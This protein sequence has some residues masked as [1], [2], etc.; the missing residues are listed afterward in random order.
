ML[1]AAS[2][3]PAAPR[4]VRF[5]SVES[6]DLG[7][8]GSV[9]SPATGVAQTLAHARTRV[10]LQAIDMLRG[11]VI[12]LMALD[13]VRDYFTDARFDPLDLT[14]THPAL[15]LT[16]W[17]TH[18]CAPTFIFLAGVS[19][20]LVSRRCTPAELSGFLFTRGLW[21]VILELTVVNYAWT[22]SV[23]YEIGVFLQVIWAIG[24]SMMLLSLLVRLP[25][26]WVGLF[27]VITIAGHNLLD[28]ISPASFGS[29][30]VLWKL[31]HVRAQTSFGLI[32]YPVG[33]WVGVMALGYALGGIFT[34]EPGFRRRVLVTLGMSFIAAFIAIRWMN[35]YGDP[36][37]WSA[38]SSP[39]YTVFAFVDVEKYPP[40]L[41]YVLMT[42]GP[43]MLLL[44]CF[45]T[46]RGK[47]AIALETFGRVPLFAYLLH[48]VVAHLLAGIVAYATGY[49]TA[50]L[51]SFVFQ[52]PEGWGFGLAGVYLAWLV[53]LALLYPLCRWFGEVK[54]RRSDWWLSY[55]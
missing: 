48:I 30:A 22:F 55:L 25:V 4:E 51:T 44:A 10:R 28:G 8:I 53:V 32:L 40:S 50:L 49:G 2:G 21:L 43:A 38:Q 15:F 3:Q 1:R 9:S 7:R 27:A 20:W 36:Q 33:P 41:L 11:L 46:L 17:V 54:R 37:P 45:E 39:L 5:M 23:H 24:I 35:G 42:L 16:R 31:L 29:F 12:V 14:Q 52:T 26:Q 19:A 47:W 34:L 6:S 13:H 18:Y